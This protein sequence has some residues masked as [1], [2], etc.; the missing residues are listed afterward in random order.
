MALGRLF[1]KI[2]GIGA[3]VIARAAVD[4]Y[5]QALKNAMHNPS[6]NGNII[7]QATGMTLEEASKILNV[8]KNAP[9]AEVMRKY[10]HLFQMNDKS[11]GGSFYLQSKIVRA[12]ERFEQEYPKEQWEQHNE[13]TT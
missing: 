12:R 11:K 5:H 9:V 13:N 7:R 4:A 8:D 2:I 10:R 1:M 6:M 3:Q